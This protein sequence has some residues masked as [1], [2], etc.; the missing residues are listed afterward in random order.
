M[1]S[2]TS[3]NDPKTA[4]L[5]LMS[6]SKITR[7]PVV[8]AC[9]RS[10][11]H[12]IQAQAANFAESKAN[13]PRENCAPNAAHGSPGFWQ[14]ILPQYWLKYSASPVLNLPTLSALH[15]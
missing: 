11:C 15:L 12:C 4:L 10:L 7:V 3:T 13:R 5:Q 8:N 1:Q 2:G 9:V 6:P 14:T